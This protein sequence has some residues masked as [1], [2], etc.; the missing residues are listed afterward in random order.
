MAP[1][2]VLM[3]V[4]AISLGPVSLVSTITGTRPIFV[5]IFGTFLS[6]SRFR[7]LEDP[8]DPKTLTVKLISI[9]MIVVG[10]AVLTLS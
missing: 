1:L 6:T 8:L 5:F 7:L 3:N 10:I 2:A 9:V 4:T